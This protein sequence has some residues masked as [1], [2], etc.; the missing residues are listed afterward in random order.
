MADPAGPW[1]PLAPAAATVRAIAGAIGGAV[2]SM[3]VAAALAG[4]LVGR[5]GVPALIGG[6][7]VVVTCPIVGA[8]CGAWLGYLR[9]RRTRWQLDA[10]GLHVRRGLLW[11]VEVLVPRSRVQHLDVERGPL[12][13]QF[14][15]ATLVVHTAGTQTAALRLSGLDD[16]DAVAL[17]DALIPDATQHVDAL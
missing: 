6:P 10:V 17:R 12:E 8:A 1:R 3:P 14:A 13:R 2:L 15:L 4:L 16:H 7:A 9:W 5:L 11:H